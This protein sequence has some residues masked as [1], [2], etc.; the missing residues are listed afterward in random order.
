M[1]TATIVGTSNTVYVNTPDTITITPNNINSYFVSNSSPVTYIWKPSS[2][3]TKN[4]MSSGGSTRYFHFY[5]G[6]SNSDFSLYLGTY[7]ARTAAGKSFTNI[8]PINNSNNVLPMS[9]CK[10]GDIAN[11]AT[12]GSSAV[13]KIIVIESTS[14]TDFN[15]MIGDPV[16]VGYTR[17]LSGFSAT[18]VG[19]D[20]ST[21]NP[22]NIPK[23]N[24]GLIKGFSSCTV[25]ITPSPTRW[26]YTGGVNSGTHYIGTTTSK[27]S[28]A[29]ATNTS[30]SGSVSLTVNPINVSGNLSATSVVSNNLNFSRTDSFSLGETVQS[31]ISPS[32][33]QLSMD[34][35]TA[36]ISLNYSVD[37]INRKAIVGDSSITVTKNPITIYYTITNMDTT[38]STNGT[39]TL[40][41]DGSSLTN[42]SDNL[43]FSVS[44]VALDD[45]SRYKVEAYLEDRLGQ[46]S[47]TLTYILP[48]AFQ[49]MDILPLTSLNGPGIAFGKTATTHNAIVFTEDF[50]PTIEN[51]RNITTP[52]SDLD[53][54]FFKC[55]RTANP[56]ANINFGIGT[57]G[58]NRGI[59]LEHQKGAVGATSGGAW[60]IYSDG[61][62]VTH[63]PASDIRLAGHAG[64]IGEVQEDYLDQQTSVASG[65]WQ[66]I[67][68]I[69]LNP[70]TWLIYMTA[71]WNSKNSGKYEGYCCVG[72]ASSATGDAWSG[73][74]YIHNAGLNVNY[75][76]STMVFRSPTSVT[77]YYCRARQTTGGTQV[78]PKGV[79][80][81]TN[82]IYAVRIK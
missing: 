4:S 71:Q 69:T 63:L 52:T 37:T 26:S 64:P 65:T 8:T 34:R 2:I 62:G 22:N 11:Y 80:N 16:A 54:A 59:Y 35:D 33:S 68:Q 46:T 3:T 51:S 56:N 36:Q 29:G 7:S 18:M 17:T 61:D 66:T 38:V 67:G 49:Y 79:S 27:V 39:Y 20:F 12:V 6:Y 77:T 47:N 60:L 9:K 14:I 31:Y 45:N 10:I 24:F 53:N 43:T 78:M 57:N 40:V 19:C 58:V 30:T 1:G 41:A 28:F 42:I 44:G 72:L 15:T 70:G 5:L 50:R 73:A 25:S 74:A 81:A 13:A 55:K 32:I 76:V 75:I 23:S 48:A 82:C 21:S